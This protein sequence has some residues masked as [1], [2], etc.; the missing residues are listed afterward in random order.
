MTHTSILSQLLQKVDNDLRAAVNCVNNLKLLMK[1][2]RDVSNNDTYDEIYQKAAAL[3]SPE[4]I[5]MLRVVK[6]QT[7]RSNVP[8]ESPK[9][10]YLRNL[11]Y[12]F[13]DSV[14][15]QL[16]QRFSGN[17]KAVLR[18]S[19]LL[20]TTGVTTNFCEV[21]PAVNLFLPLL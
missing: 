7:M 13:L 10:Y 21:E 14:I 19:S 8:V 18:L 17:A 5:S 3:V 11:Y 9:N 16:D 1:S 12:P 20:S 4:E 15:L 2:R 6:R